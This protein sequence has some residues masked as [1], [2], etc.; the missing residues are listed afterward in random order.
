MLS[1]KSHF[2]SALRAT[3]IR[4][5]L[6]SFLVASTFVLPAIAPAQQPWGR[7]IAFPTSVQWARYRSVNK[8]RLQIAGDPQFR[9]VFYDGLVRG[10][11]YK[12]SHLF[13]GYYYWRVAPVEAQR[14]P[15]SPPVRFFVSGGVVISRTPPAR[16]PTRSRSFGTAISNVR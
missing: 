9:N 4:L 11:R 7:P 12:V 15:F 3:S 13:A 2:V 16:L 10:D 1:L 14:G 8:Y 5:L 6:A